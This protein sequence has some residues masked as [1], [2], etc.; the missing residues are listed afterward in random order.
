M[1]ACLA[2]GFPFVFGFSVYEGF[3]SSEVARTGKLNLPKPKEAFM[4]GH[5][6]MAVGYDDKT[7]RFIVRNSWATDWGLDGYFTMPYEYL[8]NENLSDDFWTI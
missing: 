8:T 1:K 5:A 2:E 7:S 3:E 6:V 4:G